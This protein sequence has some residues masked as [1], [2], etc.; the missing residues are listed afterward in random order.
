MVLIRVCRTV[1]GSWCSNGTL[2]VELL[3]VSDAKF[4]PA[5]VFYCVLPWAMN[6]ST[7]PSAGKA[8]EARGSSNVRHHDRLGILVSVCKVCQE[9]SVL[10][11][12]KTWLQ[13]FMKTNRLQNQD[14]KGGI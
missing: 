8:D 14:Q 1:W 2:R 9:Q 13:L 5:Q 6:Y 10:S 12:R 3:L 7:F 11:Y 4:T